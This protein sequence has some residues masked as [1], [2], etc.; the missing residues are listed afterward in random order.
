MEYSAYININDLADEAKKELELFY[1]YLLF[2][3]KQPKQEKKAT[4]GNKVERFKTFADQHLIDLP[5][6]YKFSREEANER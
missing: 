1:E 4:P 3:Y 2:K 6:D 5:A